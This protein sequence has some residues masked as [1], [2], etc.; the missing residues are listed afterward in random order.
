LPIADLRLPNERRLN[1]GIN[2]SAIGNR[3]S[4]IGNMMM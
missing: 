1:D 3:K 4:E 2:D